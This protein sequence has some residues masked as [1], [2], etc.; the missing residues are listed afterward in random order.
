MRYLRVCLLLEKG[1]R[2]GREPFRPDEE[3]LYQTVALA[4][5]G[6]LPAPPRRLRLFG[7]LP[8]G[9]NHHH[10]APV[11]V[12]LA[13]DPPQVL[14]VV[15]EPYQEPLAELGVLHLAAPEHDRNLDLVAAAQK[16]LDVSSLG[17]EVVVTYLGS[18]L[19][20]P[21]VDVDLL[22]AGGLAGLLLL[23]LVL[24]VVHGAD[25]GRVGVRGYLHEVQIH[26]LGVVH[27]FADV[28]YPQLLAVGRDQT[29]RPCPDLAVDPRFFF[30]R[31]CEPTPLKNEI[32]GPPVH[33]TIDSAKA[34][35]GRRP[36]L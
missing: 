12:G 17:V 7:V 14:K 10:V 36:H 13:L 2:H 8:R 26:P 5:S 33:S 1:S 27:C 19:Y 34:S 23:V 22:L 30:S 18:E 11:E 24:A 3:L 25:H 31:Y 16:A 28:L 4:A 35:N 6:L 15:R 9:Q 29:N 21:H 20:L 32:S